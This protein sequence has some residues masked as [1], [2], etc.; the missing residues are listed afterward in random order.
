[1]DERS[2]HYLNI[3]QLGKAIRSGE[4]SPVEITECL[5]DRFEQF[6]GQLHAIKR[7]SPGGGKGG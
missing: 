4:L 1:M 6:D 3:A 7:L 5:L 2:I